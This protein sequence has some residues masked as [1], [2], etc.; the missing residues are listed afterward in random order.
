MSFRS[1]TCITLMV[2]CAL[3]FSA[4]SYKDNIVPTVDKT[5]GPIAEVIEDRLTQEPAVEVV[6]ERQEEPAVEVVE[7]KQEEATVEVVEEKQEEPAVEVVEEKQ[8]ELAVEVVEE[9]Q[10]EPAV[11]VVEDKQEELA[12]EVVEEKQEEPAV[13][14]IEDKP[15]VEVP[16]TIHKI[17]LA[18][19]PSYSGMPYIEINNNNPFFS[20]DEFVTYAFEKYSPLDSK[21]RC[22]VA[23]ANICKEIMPTEERGSIGM[24]KPSGWNT[25]KYD[26][27]EGKYLYNR[28][29]LIAYQ[30]AG[31]NAN[32]RNLITGTRYLNAVTMI[33][34][35]NKVA[36]YVLATNN[37]VLYRVTPMFDGDNLVATGVLM[38]GYSVED[39]GKGIC[40]NVFCYNVQP[41]VIINYSN[42]ESYAEVK[43]VEE[44][45]IE[46]TIA[47]APTTEIKTDEVT[48][49][50]NQKSNKFHYPYCSSVSSMNEENKVFFYCTREEIV[51]KG[52]DPCGRCHP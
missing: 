37:H 11:E 10:E 2:S 12:V 16:Q 8:E 13:E 36:Q 47:P 22:G 15:V 26:F 21:S 46:T 40:Y 51:A 25:V 3:F 29:H 28:C 9:R 5:N 31:E 38:E 43:T 32:V 1:K 44:P 33:Q 50:G 20:S 4:C 34:F 6:E 7:E 30:L 39:N 17:S 23:Y 48:Y 42:G 24:V 45:T 27:I 52:Y 41:G 35:E 14:V 49:I 18:D 19:I